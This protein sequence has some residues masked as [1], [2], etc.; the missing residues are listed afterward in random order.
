ML[1]VCVVIPTRNEAKS[2]S[3]V[4]RD[5]EKGLES[6]DCN[7]LG[8]FV[9]DDSYDNTKNEARRAG[10]EVIRGD[11][12]GLGAAMLKG[13]KIAAQHKPDVIVSVDGDGQADAVAE[14]PRF[15]S[16]IRKGEAELV[17]GSRFCGDNLV[18]YKYHPLN[19]LGTRI[20]AAMLRAQTGLPLTDSHG[21]I[22]SMTCEVALALELLGT[23]TYVQ[24]AILDAAEKGFKI[25]E[26]PSIWRKREHGKSRVVS[27]IPKYVIYTLPILV[28]RSGQHIRFLYSLGLFSIMASVAYFS[29]ILWQESFSFSIGHRTPALILVA[30]L[31]TAGLQVFFFGFVLQLLKQIIKSIDRATKP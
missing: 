30:L 17:L 19:R 21:G 16:P 28:L 5:V 13:L 22:R 6:A 31:F 15:I 12:E 11:G 3:N 24:E 25:K 1:N 10:A 7:R 2:I 14:L 26:I 8:I 27:S 20:L 23:H 18:E 29:L 4:I 9:V